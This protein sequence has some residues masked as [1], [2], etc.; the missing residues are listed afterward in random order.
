MGMG[1]W[2]MS[3]V[4]DLLK[5]SAEDSRPTLTSSPTST[6]TTSQPSTPPQDILHSNMQIT[7]PI[8]IA[9]PSRNS[10]NSP[11]SQGKK[12]ANYHGIED[13]RTSAL[14]SGSNLDP[15]M[16]RSRQDS[17]ASAK[18]ISMVNPNRNAD[19]RPRRESLAG[20]L[21]GGMSWGGVSVGS[22]VR[23]E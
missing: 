20:S 18:P 7:S 9:T 3:A 17:F 15:N 13:S 16:G 23:D 1:W 4:P 6:P 5:S 21:V 2:P 12:S 8:D 11:A 19:G 22:W 10:S 14:M